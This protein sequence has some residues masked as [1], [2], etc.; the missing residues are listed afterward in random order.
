MKILAIVKYCLLLEILNFGFASSGSPCPLTVEILPCSCKKQ[1]RDTIISCSFKSESIYQ[2]PMAFLRNHSM[3]VDRFRLF[4]SSFGQIKSDFWHGF[5]MRSVELQD[6]Q[7]GAISADMFA[8]QWE[9]LEDVSYLKMQ[10]NGSISSVVPRLPNL[11]RFQCSGSIFERVESNFS[12]A[13]QAPAVLRSLK[14]SHNGIS[15]VDKMAFSGFISLMELDLS[16]NW[17][18]E[19]ASVLPKNNKVIS[20]M[21]G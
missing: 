20:L 9:S 15:V 18:A 4:K 3:I 5:V 2:K 8:S 10:T 6:S 16:G 17:I 14:L 7:I 19:L 21:L 1:G 13:F 12:Q 11:E